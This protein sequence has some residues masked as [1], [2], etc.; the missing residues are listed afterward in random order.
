ME[1][2]DF[3]GCPVV[4]G[5]RESN[6]HVLYQSNFRLI[7]TYAMTLEDLDLRVRRALLNNNCL[8]E[9]DTDAGNGG[10]DVT[11]PTKSRVHVSMR[12][13]GLVGDQTITQLTYSRDF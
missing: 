2:P 4:E 5:G 12:Q 11:T 8:V 7:A 9:K 13:C 10:F 3:H 1:H 6:A